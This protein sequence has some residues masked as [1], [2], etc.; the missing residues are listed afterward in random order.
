MCAPRTCLPPPKKIGSRL[1]A[2]YVRS[3]HMFAQTKSDPSNSKI[4]GSRFALAMC[5]T[6]TC[7]PPHNQSLPPILPPHFLKPGAATACVETSNWIQVHDILCTVDIYAINFYW[8]LQCVRV[9]FIQYLVSLI[10]VE[11][12]KLHNMHNDTCTCMCLIW[13]LMYLAIMRSFSHI[14][15]IKF[16]HFTIWRAI[17]IILVAIFQSMTTVFNTHEVFGLHVHFKRIN[18][19]NVIFLADI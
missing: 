16:K 10:K 19:N 5:A 9:G 2:R 18:W 7:L 4:I 14:M 1:R 3:A 6:R 8:L 13:I 17:Y 11:C 15:K 12:I